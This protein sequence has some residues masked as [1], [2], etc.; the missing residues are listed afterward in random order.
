M[1]NEKGHG[2][3]ATHFLS[4]THKEC[5]DCLQ[6][7]LH[8]EFHKNA[9]NPST[10]NLAYYCKECANLRGKIFHN[11]HKD[12]LSYKEKKLC[13]RTR[14]TYK[15]TA[16]EYKQK[17]ASQGSICVICK[18]PLQTGTGLT[19]LDHDHKTGKIRDFL[20]TNC[21]RGLGHFQ[22][23]PLVLEEAAKYLRRHNTSVDSIKE[24][25]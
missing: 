12:N 8:T 25:N 3:V 23:N 22:D 14:R 2:R 24:G 21:N 20:C 4:T 17:L 1:K 19:H 7:K 11:K 6:V 10:N 13:T 15:L 9:N 18:I 16:V 5:S